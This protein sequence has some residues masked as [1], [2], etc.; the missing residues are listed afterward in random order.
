MPEVTTGASDYGR[1]YYRHEIGAGDEPYDWASPGWRAFFTG[2]AARLKATFPE[3]GTVLDVG[4]AKGLLVQ[5]FLAEGLEASGFDISE[6][7]FE[8]ADPAVREHLAV[9]SATE[10]I[11]G[12]YDLITCIEVLEHL[13]SADAEAAIDAMTAATDRIVFSST[14]DDYTEPTHVNVRPVADWLAAFAT[15]GFFRRTDVD[16]SFIAPWAVCVERGTPSLRD[17]VHR[18]ESALTPL[19]VEVVA[20]RAALLDAQRELTRA[21]ARQESDEVRR[22]QHEL[23]RLRDHAIGAEAAAGAARAALE[24]KERE[25]GALRD[26]EAMKLGRAAIRPVSVVKRGVKKVLGD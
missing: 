9:R 16:V 5:A 13:G 25:L 19:R 3:T 12:R 20:K 22:L 21:E 17:L 14:A 18:Y 10:P 11:E 23:L 24:Q 15:R 2:V 7:A 8:D 4:A 1:R 26:S 6:V